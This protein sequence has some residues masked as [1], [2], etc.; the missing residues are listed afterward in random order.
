MSKVRIVQ[1]ERAGSEELISQSKELNE[2][3]DTKLAIKV[4]RNML[5]QNLQTR[6][7]SPSNVF[8]IIQERRFQVNDLILGNKTSGMANLKESVE[9]LKMQQPDHD[10]KDLY[11]F[12]TTGRKRRQDLGIA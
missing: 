12:E 4:E 2:L 11:R 6:N 1:G 5:N 10:H 8:N 9:A 7:P 3:D